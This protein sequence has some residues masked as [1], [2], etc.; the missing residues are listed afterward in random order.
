MPPSL[1]FLRI[2]LPIKGLLW[3]HENFRI[4]FYFFEKC[5]WNFHRDCIES[6]C[7][8]ECHKGEFL[9]I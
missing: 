8:F 6:I 3:L 4:V 1:F 5:H 9:K 7:W 2:A